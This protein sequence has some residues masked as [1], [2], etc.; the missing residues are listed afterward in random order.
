MRVLLSNRQRP[1]KKEWFTFPMGAPYIEHAGLERLRELASV[2]ESGDAAGLMV[3]DLESP[4]PNLHCFVPEDATPEQLNTLAIKLGYMDQ[5]DLVRFEGALN[6]NCVDGME[7]VLRLADGLEQYEI[8]PD[9]GTETMLGRYLV[10]HGYI[11]FPEKF[12]PYINY[13]RVGI[14]FHAGHSG[15]FCGVN[16]VV[17]KEAAQEEALDADRPQ[18]F[19]VHL[20]TPKVGDTMPGP[21]RLILPACE[22]RLEQ[23]KKLLG[24]D[25]FAQ[26]RIEQV[27]YP[28]TGLQEYL[29]TADCPSVET[30]NALAEEVEEIL[31]T[32]GQLLKLCGV[33]EAEQ[34]RTLD[35]ALRITRNLDDYERVPCGQRPDE[36]GRYV[37]KHPERFEIEDLL[38]DLEGFV[39]EDGYG[40]YRMQEDGV[41]AT[42]CGLIRRLSN[43]F[44]PQESGMSMRQG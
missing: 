19:K 21:Y 3:R 22:E 35:E 43:P 17:R 28:L 30:L 37:M 42:G 12:L 6:I 39:D 14:E 16:Y 27:E 38:E 13:A 7:D 40:K 25:D 41:R 34:P 44:P 32:D 15:A 20:Y 11:E 1:E 26:A 5:E 33:L 24:V 8:Y 29:S 36:Y 31:Q 18:V 4:I 10:A 23:V 2:P 9:T